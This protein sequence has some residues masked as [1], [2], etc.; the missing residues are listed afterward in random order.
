MF[1]KTKK[2]IKEI[3][4]DKKQIIIGGIML[5]IVTIVVSLVASKKKKHERDI[6][7]INVTTPKRQTLPLTLSVPST[8]QATAD[9]S[10]RN[11]VDG[12]I[13]KV[14]FKEGQH[15]KEGD[16]LIEID[17]E[18]LQTQLR[19]AEA[20]KAKDAASLSQSEKEL[21]RNTQLAKRDMASKS[22]FDKVEATTKGLRAS[23][24]FDQALI[25]SLKIQIGHARIKS[26]I[27]GTAGF[28]KV[29]VGNFVRQSENV[30]L[31][32]IKKI[33]PITVLFE[34][35]ERF[36]P[37][38]LK[39]KMESINVSLT[40]IEDKPIKANTKVVAFNSGVD[41][42]SGTL[43]VKVEVENKD[44]T[45]RPGMSVVGKIQF[46]EHKNAITIPVESLQIGQDGAFVFTYD[47]K[48]KIVQKK[49]VVVKDTLDAVVVIESGISDTDIVVTEGQ[50]RLTNGAKA[51]IQNENEAIKAS[52]KVAT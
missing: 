44:L 35:P 28:L 41:T 26:P 32:S 38:L 13:K 27:N 46:G 21:M 8:F 47:K 12:A 37:A 45:Q 52:E 39:S 22:A 49:P 34:I 50:I 6:P 19:Q 31:V 43:W 23:V 20:T 3:I 5:C 17:D 29:A 51:V 7:F 15:I 30:P 10:I 25:D 1:D 18:L 42:K 40:D 2:I 36:V 16:L 4:I 11:R 33:N 14:Y 24:A 9:V 48:N